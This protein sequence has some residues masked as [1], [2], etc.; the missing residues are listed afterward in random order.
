MHIRLLMTLPA[1]AALAACVTEP[2]VSGRTAFA[3]DCAACHG[4]DAKGAGVVGR[5][6]TPVPPD[7]TVL[8]RNN[9]G[10]FPRDHVMSTIDGLARS[11]HFSAA[12]P[13]FGDGDM[14]PVAIV[15]S[16]DGLGTP[17]PARLLA[18]AD[19]LA[20]LQGD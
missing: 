11:A 20:S 6:L 19:Y 16:Q 17:V 7:L 14:G 4:D 2:D 13:V 10:V 8:A 3:E 9:G 1:L 15:E 18:L 12:M 5:T